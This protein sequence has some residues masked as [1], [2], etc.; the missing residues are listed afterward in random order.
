MLEPITVFSIDPLDNG[1]NKALTVDEL[2]ALSIWLVYAYSTRDVAPLWFAKIGNFAVRDGDVIKLKGM[3]GAMSM[4][5]V[6][7]LLD[8]IADQARGAQGRLHGHSYPTF[9]EYCSPDKAG[10]VYDNDNF[11]LT[12]DDDEGFSYLPIALR[13]SADLKVWYAIK[14]TRDVFQNLPFCIRFKFTNFT[15]A[16]I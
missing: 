11:T 12:Y 16:Q 4:D 3:E 10:V 6:I 2:T 9:N 5:T 7:R 14:G 1:Y 8:V 15:L 13:Y